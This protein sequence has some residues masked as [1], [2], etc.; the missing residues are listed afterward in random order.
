MKIKDKA[1]AAEKF[2]AFMAAEPVD[3]VNIKELVSEGRA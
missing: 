2:K 1:A 3:G